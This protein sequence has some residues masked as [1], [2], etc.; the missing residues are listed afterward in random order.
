M[1]TGDQSEYLRKKMAERKGRPRP[2]FMK[3]G[4][5]AWAE[6]ERP[7]RMGGAE[8][9][10]IERA[11][12]GAKDVIGEAKRLGKQMFEKFY[13]EG[14]AMES[15]EESE[16]EV[17]GRVFLPTIASKR[18][19]K[20][21]GKST[22]ESEDSIHNV[23]GRVFLPTIASKRTTKG[24]GK[25]TVG[26]EDN[27]RGVVAR[28]NAKSIS[29]LGKVAADYLA[30]APITK[31]RGKRVPKELEEEAEGE[32]EFE[33]SGKL[34]IEHKDSGHGAELIMG[35]GKKKPSARGEIVKKVMREK[36]LSLPQASKY[37]KEHGLYKA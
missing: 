35:K 1:S 13:K 12:D 34:V 16:R 30:G 7:T 17:G 26:S 33:G 18:T 2:T 9:E 28:K 8:K 3:S 31:G 23:G 25:S 22:V 10:P 5:Q 19:T 14:G 29:V 24:K 32:I 11:R 4:F 37:V 15:E 21:K 20:G 27:P 36:G 6:S